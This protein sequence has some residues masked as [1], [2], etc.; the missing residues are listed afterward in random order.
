MSDRTTQDRLIAIGRQF[1]DRAPEG[2]ASIVFRASISRGGFVHEVVVEDTG[3]ESLRMNTRLDP[4]QKVDWI[5]HVERRTAVEMRIQ[6]DREFTALVN[7][8]L[9]Q[10]PCSVPP[11]YE[12]VLDERY[13]PDDRIAPPVAG[14]ESGDPSVIPGL[15]AEYA[16]LFESI[17]GYAPRFNPPASEDELAA[18]EQKLG[19]DLPE[20]VK[21][22]YRVTGGDAERD[23]VFGTAVLHTLDFVAEAREDF[24][25]MDRGLR[26]DPGDWATAMLYQGPEGA[27][28]RVRWSKGWLPIAS[29]GTGRYFAIDLDPGPNG[30]R[31]QVIQ[32]N[33]DHS[34]DPIRY[35]A[36]S[37]AEYLATVLGL[38]REGAYVAH[39]DKEYFYRTHAPEE[40]PRT[41]MVMSLEGQDLRS[42]LAAT[43]DVESLQRL[44]LRHAGHVELAPLAE[45]PLLRGLRVVDSDSVDFRG[46]HGCPLEEIEV[47]TAETDLAPLAGHPSLRALKVS[48][49]AVVAVAPAP[50]LSI[51]DLS[52][53][54][55]PDLAGVL[56][57]PA[58]K[59]LTLHVDQW[60]EVRDRFATPAGLVAATITGQDSLA[61][62]AE[63]ASWLAGGPVAGRTDV[64]HIGGTLPNEEVAVPGSSTRG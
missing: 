25:A 4:L 62:A 19:A 48:G 12:F 9:R 36:P 53:A 15:V 32:V 7:T 52:N 45:L 1:V 14:R 10:S 35:V 22:L 31:G 61:H 39:P 16:E 3:G 34:D 33:G 47:K 41:D 63:W 23:G 64:E 6:P 5:R 54:V 29:Y 42:A 27:V 51:V 11:T 37:V 21:A 60:Q 50:G 2:W 49:G 57:L 55:V 8:G 24:I 18:V 44:T 38:L 17:M 43:E 20:D 56:G 59:V 58:L 28:R 13:R 30:R 46:L 40:Y 26:A